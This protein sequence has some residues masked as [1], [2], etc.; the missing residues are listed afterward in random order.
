[1]IKCHFR[2]A[3]PI[4]KDEYNKTIEHRCKSLDGHNKNIVTYSANNLS[5][6]TESSLTFKFS[7]RIQNHPVEENRTSGMLNKV[8][9]GEIR[10]SLDISKIL[11]TIVIYY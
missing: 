8:M 7:E 5:P 11:V 4:S 3:D 9:I 10:I 2:E 1:M 6:E